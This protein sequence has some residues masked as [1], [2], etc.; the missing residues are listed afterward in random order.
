MIVDFFLTN[1]PLWA[2][3]ISLVAAGLILLSDRRPNLRETITMLAA[4]GKFVIVLT[5][6]PD[7]LAG[8]VVESA[9]LK[10]A[11]GISLHLRAD[12]LGLLFALL[13]SGLWVVTSVYSIGYMRSMKYGHETGY[14]ASFAVC[15]SAAVGIALAANLLTFFVFYEI[16]TI[17]TYPLVVHART[18]EAVSGGR[19]YLVYTLTA[20]Q[21]LLI[22]VVWAQVV[23]PGAE[24]RPGGFLAG[25][26]T[27]PALDI[28]FIL[29][30]LGLGVK[31]AIMPLH[32]WLPT[33][34]VAPTPVS[35]LLHA[36]AVVKA[37][38]FGFLRIT[39]YVFGPELL[40]ETNLGSLLAW[41]AALTIIV[42]SLRALAEDN[43]K[44]RLAYSTVGQ[45]SYVVLGAALITPM[46]LVG[47]MFHIVAHAFMKITLFFCAGAI[48]V[49]THKENV[50]EMDGIGRQ[51]PLTMGAF[52]LG[53]LGIVGM[54]FVVGFVSKWNLG[55]GALQAGH[56][57]FVAVLVASALLSTGYFF[58]I[59]YKAYFGQTR[60]TYSRHEAKPSL[61]YPLVLTALVS[62]VLGIMPNFGLSFYQLAKMAAKSIIAS[63][64]VL[65]GGGQ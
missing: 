31:A 55:L 44:R 9:P 2:V 60:E 58:P 11:P 18:P 16:L 62:L 65:A 51:M 32:D 39:G 28:M 38:A 27:P 3:L 35:A 22:A 53:S 64:M 47:G 13:S 15:L 57:I 49:T 8:Q 59:V 29:F 54:P 12:A 41:I 20:G 14:Y 1:R 33:A 50:S 43:L 36:V 56:P 26:I 19:K 40:K 5:M 24:F 7:V 42:A 37:G 48:Y 23:A 4:V 34:M 63:G 10:L 21:L 30:I 46:S 6:L 45:L 52:T 17:A 25:R 61:L